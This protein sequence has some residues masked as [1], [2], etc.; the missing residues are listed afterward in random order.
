MA[1]ELLTWE[2][3]RKACERCGKVPTIRQARKFAKGKGDVFKM[4][5]KMGV[6]SL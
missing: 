2:P 4:A 1:R 5:Q 6:V 3:F